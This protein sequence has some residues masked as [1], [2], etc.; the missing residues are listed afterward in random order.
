MRKILFV[1][2]LL[3]VFFALA[4]CSTP[5]AQ[6]IH[7]T[8]TVTQPPQILATTV[9]VT[10]VSTVTTPVTT[11]GIAVVPPPIATTTKSPTVATGGGSS[12]NQP[13]SVGTTAKWTV[14][15]AQN[16]GNTLPVSESKYKSIGSTKTTA[17]NFIKIAVTVENT[18]KTTA[19]WPDE[20]T[21][22][23]S[24]GREYKEADGTSEYVPDGMEWSLPTLQPNIPKQ[25]IMFFEVPKD[26]SGLSL[27][28]NDLT[29]S[30]LSPAKSALIG[31]GF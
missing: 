11:T 26:A 8:V 27:K 14:T 31:L 15:S 2:L 30:F 9:T 13:V 10:V 16:K 24:Q 29:R 18:G 21:V 25:F 20:P 6:V 7:D 19:E 4:A 12:I 28:A 17:G 5:Q 3:G 22:V 1:L 23:D